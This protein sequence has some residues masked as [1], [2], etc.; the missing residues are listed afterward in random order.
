MINQIQHFLKNEKGVP[1]PYRFWRDTGISRQVAYELWNNPSRLPD[2]R[3]YSR[4]CEHYQ[5]QLS[6][7]II[8]VPTSLSENFM[9]EKDNLRGD[10]SAVFLPE[11]NRLR[12][13]A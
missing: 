12:S 8:W 3:S 1:T 11:N 13:Q 5:A 6:D 4:I 7:F 2:A 10:G 9:Y